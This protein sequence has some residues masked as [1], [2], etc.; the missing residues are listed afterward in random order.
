VS[1][2]ADGGGSGTTV[3]GGAG[4]GTG[5]GIPVAPA[6]D[7]DRLELPGQMR[8]DVRLLGGMLGEV[9]RESGGQDLLDDVERLRRAVIEARRNPGADPAGDDIAVLVGSW[10]LDR[11]ELVARAFTV[12][13][14]LTNLAEER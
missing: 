11:A 5:T 13:F 8:R 1:Q 3:T 2:D 9:L 10:P 12:Y 14:H 6:R 4:T 7:T